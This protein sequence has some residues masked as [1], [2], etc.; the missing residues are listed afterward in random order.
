MDDLARFASTRDPELR[1]QLAVRHLPLVKFVARKMSASLPDHIELD[2]LVSWGSLGLLDAIDKFQPALGNKFST[3]AVTR[4]R[5]AILDGLQQMDWAPKQIT[6]KVRALRRAQ[7]RLSAQLGREP[8]VEELA[9]ALDVADGEIRGWLLDAQVTRVKAIYGGDATD[10]GDADR[11]MP[12]ELAEQD[13]VGEVAEIRTRMCVA[14]RCLTDRERALLLL[15]YRDQKTL[16]QIAAELGV[17]V[18]SVTQTH[19]RLVESVRGRLS[20]LGGVA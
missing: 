1:G 16:R 14:I 2:D 11:L 4:I 6:S 20:A 15:Y 9:E 3:Y 17:S 8:S 19:T 18:S 5:G 7:E 10:E 12:P 13:V